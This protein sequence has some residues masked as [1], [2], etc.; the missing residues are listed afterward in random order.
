LGDRSYKRKIATE[1][2]MSIFTDTPVGQAE[3]AALTIDELLTDLTGTVVD[4]ETCKRLWAVLDEPDSDRAE[5]TSKLRDRI[6]G[7]QAIIQV[8]ADELKRRTA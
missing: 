6:H 8:I 2:K 3:I 5:L 7:N 1:A 4:L